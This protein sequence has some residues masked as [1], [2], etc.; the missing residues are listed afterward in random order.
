MSTIACLAP[1]GRRDG[2]GGFPDDGLNVN[3]GVRARRCFQQGNVAHGVCVCVCVCAAAAA[4]GG[5]GFHVRQRLLD[6][7][8]RVDGVDL[9]DVPVSGGC[10]RVDVVRWVWSRWVWSGGCGHGGCGHGGCGQ[11]GCGKEGC[12]QV[13]C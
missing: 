9:G 13:W 5:G 12:G 2:G 11:C 3:Q 6:G 8:V 4:A 1:G 7:E 10:D